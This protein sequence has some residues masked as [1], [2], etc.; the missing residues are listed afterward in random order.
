MSNS[1]F[2]GIPDVFGAMM[3]ML[4]IFIPLGLWK[5]IEIIIWICHHVTVGVK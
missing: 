5:A 4:C 2:E 1:P 3:I